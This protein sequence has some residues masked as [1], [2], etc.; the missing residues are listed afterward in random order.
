MIFFG[1]IY[2]FIRILYALFYILIILIGKEEDY[3]ILSDSMKQN[4]DEIHMNI[5]WENSTNATKAKVIR[6]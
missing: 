4:N 6:L 5:C 3:V 2:N 1:D